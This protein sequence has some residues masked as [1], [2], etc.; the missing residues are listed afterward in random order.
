MQPLLCSGGYGVPQ[1]AGKFQIFKI[2][3]VC[4]DTSASARLTLVDSNKDSLDTKGYKDRYVLDA[5]RVAVCNANIDINLPEPI[6]VV[7]GILPLTMTNLV[8]GSVFVYVR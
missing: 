6:K 2:L 3:A 1:R 8:P 7:D 5:K 4:S